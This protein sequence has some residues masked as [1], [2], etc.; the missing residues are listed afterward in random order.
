[1]AFQ[2]V[3]ETAEIIVRGVLAGQ[4][5]I[6]T[7]Y[8]RKAGG[9][10]SPDIA[11]LADEVG[12]WAAASWVPNLC[13]GYQLLEVHVRGLESAIDYEASQDFLDTFGVAGATPLPNNVTISIKR[14]SEFTGRA[15]RGRIFVPGLA[16]E[17]LSDANTMSGES[18]EAMI[19]SLYD[20]NTVLDGLGWVAVI[21][22]RK[23]DGVAITPALTYPIVTYNF[24][25]LTLDSMRRRLPGRGG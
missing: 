9:Y 21:V 13:T 14:Q 25:D 20:L 7:H 16:E 6:N 3:P 10:T 8:A 1:M 12:D 23:S 17:Q 2:S 4:S 18:A 22:H 24:V 15:A 5:V 19:T 11:E